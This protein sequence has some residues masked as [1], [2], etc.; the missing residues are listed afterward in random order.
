LIIRY[1]DDRRRRRSRRVP[2]PNGSYEVIKE[3]FADPPLTKSFASPAA[4]GAERRR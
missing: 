3:R 4:A 1:P 2:L